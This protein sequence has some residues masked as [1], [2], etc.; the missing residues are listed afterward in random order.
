MRRTLVLAFVLA[1][2]TFAG[3][4]NQDEIRRYQVPRAAAPNEKTP[5]RLLA[6]MLP[7]QEQMWFFKMIGPE[8]AVGLHKAEFERFVSSVRFTGKADAPLTW[9]VPEGW[10]EEQQEINP[11]N[12]AGLRRFATFRVGPDDSAPEVTVLPLPR[13]AE[14]GSVLAN[15]NRWRGQLGQPPVTEAELGKVTTELKVGDAVATM[16]DITAPGTGDRR[17]AAPVAK[18]GAEGDAP[19]NYKTPQGWKRHPAG[20]FAVLAFEVNAGGKTAQVTASLLP[21]TGGGLAANVNRWRKQLDLPPAGEEQVRKD[22]REIAVAGAKAP[23]VDLL[24]PEAGGQRKE[25]LGVVVER[26]GQ[27]WFFKMTG[28]AEL[29]TRQKP[30]FEEFVRS[31]QFDA[32]KGGPR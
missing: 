1:A 4:Q 9:A 32:A 25:I 12:L 20:Q 26:G 19:V 18:G 30:A 3:C 21:G 10:R 2:V 17:D 23:Y 13:L 8:E 6:A 5:A 29:V 11:K 15:V 16:V 7:H 22:L 24:G 31:V 28:P 27:T 14:A